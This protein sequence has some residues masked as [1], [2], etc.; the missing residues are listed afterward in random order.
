MIIFYNPQSSAGRKPILPMSLLAVGAVLEGQYDYCILDGNLEADPLAALDAQ[1]QQ[2][3]PKPILALTVMPGPQLKQAVPL[4]RELKKRHPHLTVVWGGYFPT[5]HWDVCLRSEFIDYVVRGHGEYVF[6]QLLD[7]LHGRGAV[8]STQ[9][10]VLSN[11]LPANDLQSSISNL[12]A[13][14]GLAYR[15]E[16][17]EPVSNPLAPLPHPKQLPLWNFERA[18]MQRYVR[19]T[20]LGSRTLGYHSSYGCPFFCNFCAVVNLVNGKW[21]PQTAETV[22]HIAHEYKQRWNV[23]AIEFYD[24]NFFTHEARVAEFSERVM[25]LNIAWWGEGRI[26]TMQKYSERTW[27]LMHDAGLKMVFLGAESGSMETLKRMDKGGQMSPEKTLEIVKLMKSYNIIPELSFVMGNPPDAVADARQTM[28]FIRKVKQINPASEIIMYLY[29]PVPL[30]GDLYEEAQAE[31]FA[32]PKTL[33]EWVSEDWSE[34][35]QRRSDTMPWIQ[36]DLQQQIHDFERVLNA[37]YPTTTFTGMN[38]LQRAILKGVS[39]WRYY[40]RF[41]HFPIE[42][43]TLH[44]LIAYQRPE[45]AGF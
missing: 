2:S 17:G 16:A 40:T 23:N 35:S 30:A 26:D 14:A 37:Y 33:E 43:R 41:Y 44:H 27:R 13:I 11:Q 42:L 9:L 4:C 38:K 20:F 25:N 10:P 32:F 34:F 5:Q 18:N 21:L 22:S 7:H 8:I 29:T 28:E 24:N 6:L 3:G 39:A 36:R 1:I 45:T 31:G 12:Q 19:P 15:N